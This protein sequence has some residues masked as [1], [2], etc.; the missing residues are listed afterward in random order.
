MAFIS[1][2]RRDIIRGMGR[3][4]HLTFPAIGGGL[5]LAVALMAGA[6][7][8]PVTPQHAQTQADA[9]PVDLELV[10][11]VDVSYSMDPDEQALQR[12]G[13]RL[14][15]TSKEF[16]SALREGSYG[17][18]AITYIEWAG[19]FDQKIVMP[20]RLIDGPEAADA[21]A[22][23]LG[24]APYRRATRTSISGGLRFARGLFG[25]GTYRGTRRV[26]DI[27][28]DG[29][30]NNGPPVAPVRDDIVA[31]GITINGLPIML[32]RPTGTMDIENLD[33]YYEDCV[34]G[35]PG[36]FVIPIRDRAQ[37]IDAI[38]TKLVLEIAGRF[39]DAHA[40]PVSAAAPRISCT[41]G[42]KLWHDRWGDYDFR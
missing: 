39:D 12:E 1:P 16:L 22:A 30:N 2:S 6:F 14:A 17:R 26:I 29:P 24:R 40:I 38:R 33:I 35:G 28:G 37:F 42:E 20:W 34:T 41:I 3:G 5:A 11:A 4:D 13:Y 19:E 27:S 21:V 7:A 9:I 15:L 31:S 8:A 23:E 32:K 25:K 36:A 18:I 10:L